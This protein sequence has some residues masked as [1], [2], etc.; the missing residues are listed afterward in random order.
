MYRYVLP[1]LMGVVTWLML[2][3]SLRGEG[4]EEGF[5]PLFNGKDLTGWITPH[6][7][8]LFSVE[9]GV[10]VG[11]TAE[12]Q[13]K[14]NEFLVSDKSYKNFILKVEGVTPMRAS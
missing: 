6:D 10:I 14:K 5:V 13:L 11:R 7:K 12:K 9:D 4:K 8:T 1:A 3:G 2:T